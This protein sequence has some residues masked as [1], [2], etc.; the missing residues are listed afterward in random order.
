MTSQ[1][2]DGGAVD[3]DEGKCPACPV[4]VRGLYAAAHNA[5][6][7]FERMMASGES[8][9]RTIRKMQELRRAVERFRF[10]VDHHFSGHLELE[11]RK[12]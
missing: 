11:A 4:V 10:V 2:D 9:D 7:S 8:A 6:G 12:K 5:V 3:G 1:R